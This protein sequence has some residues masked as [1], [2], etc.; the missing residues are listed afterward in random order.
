M[1]RGP[2]PGERRGGRAKGTPNRRTQEQIRA[3]AESGM[4]PLQYLIS[5]MRDERA[6]PALRLDAA[7]KAAPY[8][9]PRL[10][11]LTVDL[12]DEKPERD[13]RDMSDEELLQI[14]RAEWHANGGGSDE[15]VT[16]SD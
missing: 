3:I 2:L 8:V 12:H 1:P 9:H 14:I 11:A 15:G 7:S 6:A 13:V 5:V 10:S 4:T 16:A